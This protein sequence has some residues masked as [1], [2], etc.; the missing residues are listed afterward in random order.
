MNDLHVKWGTWIGVIE[1]VGVSALW[2]VGQV[3][4]LAVGDKDIASLALP[5]IC[6]VIVAAVATA[7]ICW[8]VV[9]WVAL[10]SSCIWALDAESWSCCCYGVAVKAGGAGGYPW[11]VV[12]AV[13]AVGVVAGRAGARWINEILGAAGGAGEVIITYSAV[14][15]AGGACWCLADCALMGKCDY[16][17]KDE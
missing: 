11:G 6:Y 16:Q 10:M 14:G 5:K 8:A 1:A 12:V 13:V 15:G 4:P 2:A 3:A 9:D 7:S 17:C